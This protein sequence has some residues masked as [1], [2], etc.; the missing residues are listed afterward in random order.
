MFDLLSLSLAP[1]IL[2]HKSAADVQ[3]LRIENRSIYRCGLRKM[4][5]L[6]WSS[7][8][9]NP[10][11]DLVFPIE[12]LDFDKRRPTQLLDFDEMATKRVTAFFRDHIDIF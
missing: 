5:Q 6:A 8:R 4:Q 1:K 11:T 3:V 10:A 7:I 12:L 2:G 9:Q